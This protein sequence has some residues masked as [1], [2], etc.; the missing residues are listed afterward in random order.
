MDSDSLRVEPLG[1]DRKNSAYWYFYGTR[2]YRED[3]ID[4]SN[5][6]SHKQ[7]SKP[8]DKKRKKRRNRVAKE[9]QEEEEKEEASLINNGRESVWQVVCFTQQ[10]WSRL[11][12]KFRDSVIIILHYSSIKK[13]NT[14]YCRIRNKIIYIYLSRNTTPNA[15]FIVHCPRTLCR[16][17]RNYSI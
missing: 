4:T 7:K 17:Y 5:G 11:V 6:A 8:R 15:S 16:K 12:E 9:E 1:H 13:K 14:N 3:Y 2:L 10:D